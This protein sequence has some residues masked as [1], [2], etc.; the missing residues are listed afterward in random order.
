MGYISFINVSDFFFLNNGDFSLVRSQ[1]SLVTKHHLLITWTHGGFA[2][3]VCWSSSSVTKSL[4]AFTGPASEEDS[5]SEGQQ[6]AHTDSFAA[7]LLWWKKRVQHRM[8]V[9]SSILKWD[10]SLSSPQLHRSTGFCVLK[11]CQMDSR[12]VFEVGG[13][14][15]DKCTRQLG[16]VKN[17]FFQ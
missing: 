15:V 7:R 3:R 5:T 4:T 6:C 1:S 10:T 12:G 8:Y 16:H 11:L 14:A 2:Q 9:C 17:S 13:Q